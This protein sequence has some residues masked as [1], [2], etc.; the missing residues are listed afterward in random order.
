MANVHLNGVLNA[1][2]AVQRRTVYA[3]GCMHNSA[4]CFDA[5]MRAFSGKLAA[6]SI[7]FKVFF[8]APVMRLGEVTI[9]RNGE[10]QMR[11]T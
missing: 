11:T 7:T 3:E 9:H 4:K 10:Y 8:N 6:E 1:C 2:D 5:C